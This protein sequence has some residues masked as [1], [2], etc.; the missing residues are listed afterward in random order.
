MKKV[1]QYFAVVFATLLLIACSEQQYNLKNDLENLNQATKVVSL[2]E[3]NQLRLE[4]NTNKSP[5]ARVKIFNQLGALYQKLHDSVKE[6]Y[7][8]TKDAQG[9]QDELLLGTQNFVALM[10]LSAKYA[11]TPAKT[12]AQIK[13][14][15]TIQQQSV[16]QIANAMENMAKLQKIVDAEEKK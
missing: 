16:S 8:S 11:V 1:A 4:L 10:N 12:E 14:F 13:E 3:I 2:Q 6:A 5:E 15:M 7:I 9:V